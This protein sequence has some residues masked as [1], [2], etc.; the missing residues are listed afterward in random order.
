MEKRVRSR[1]SQK[2]ININLKDE[3]LLLFALEDIFYSLSDKNKLTENNPF[4][5]DESKK[6]EKNKLFDE[7]NSNNM[8]IDVQSRNEK[9]EA[10]IFFKS[11]NYFNNQSILRYFYKNFL[12]ENKDYNSLIKDKINMGCGIK[13]IV[14]QM[15]YVLTIFLVKLSDYKISELHLFI[16]NDDIKNILNN[17][18]KQYFEETDSSYRNM[19][20]SNYLLILI[21]NLKI[22]FVS[23]L[24]YY[25]C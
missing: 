11:K 25:I 19:L 1:F 10:K 14:T 20:M 17:S 21:F 3:D 15:K 16:G 5:I 18:F 8:D 7:K 23:I 4:I 12:K 22:K 2:T 24:I 6:V 13:E 9:V